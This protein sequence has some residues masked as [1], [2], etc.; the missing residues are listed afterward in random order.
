[1]EEKPKQNS[2]TNHVNDSQGDIVVKPVNTEPQA[3]PVD[4]A[5]T[6]PQVVNKEPVVE[7]KVPVVEQVVVEQAPVV[8]QPVVEQKNKDKELPVNKNAAESDKRPFIA[9]NWIK[10]VVFLLIS[11]SL[12]LG[13]FFIEQYITEASEEEGRVFTAFDYKKD[14]I[15]PE[16]GVFRFADQEFVEETP[17]IDVLMNNDAEYIFELKSGR[18][19]GNLRMTNAKVNI[20][21]DNILIIP[22]YASFDLDFDGSHVDLSVYNGDVYLAFLKDSVDIDEYVSPYSDYF[23]DDTNVSGSLNEYFINSLVVP[24]NMEVSV[25][26]KKVNDEIGPL[27]RSKLLK[28]LNMQNFLI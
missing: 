21:V 1:M 19:W 14:N 28:S 16:M 17:E 20:L 26:L 13:N 22:S 6:A 4:T 23:V 27:L 2:E 18:V 11:I 3:Q 15:L 7:Q 5:N 25:A 10:L 12:I 8:E 9:G 24:Q